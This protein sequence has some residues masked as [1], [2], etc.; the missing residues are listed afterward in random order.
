MAYRNRELFRAFRR[1]TAVPAPL[2]RW[3]ADYYRFWYET[4]VLTRRHPRAFARLNTG[5]RARRNSHLPAPGLDARRNFEIMWRHTATMRPQRF[6]AMFDVDGVA[7]D[8]A[9][10]KFREGWT[11]AFDWSTMSVRQR[12]MDSEPVDV[13][14][15]EDR[16]VQLFRAYTYLDPF[17]TERARYRKRRR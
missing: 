4:G 9:W 7:K 11:A 10:L 17:G 14:P 3:G 1:R 15:Y 13:G 8:H 6:L 12:G 2:T 5:Y 16:Y